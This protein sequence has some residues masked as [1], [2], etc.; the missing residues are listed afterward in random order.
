MS[1]RVLRVALDDV[2]GDGDDLPDG[3]VEL[4]RL[5]LVAQ[6]GAKGEMM[7]VLIRLPRDGSA[8]DFNRGVQL[9]L[10]SQCVGEIGIGAWVIGRSSTTLRYAVAASS[11]F[12][13]R[14][15]HSPRL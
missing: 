9:P 8:A 6:D 13:W 15:R 5:P 3:G 12:F 14:V 1:A 7:A 4:L 10:I 11:S 2:E